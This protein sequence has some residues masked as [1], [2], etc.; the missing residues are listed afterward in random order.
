MFTTKREQTEAMVEHMI[1]W[2]INVKEMKPDEMNE[3]LTKILIDTAAKPIDKRI[4]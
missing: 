4:I 2:Q 1:K 3:P